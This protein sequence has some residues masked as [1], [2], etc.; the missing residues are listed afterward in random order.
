[1]QAGGPLLS[2]QS[3]KPGEG[4][5]LT[6]PTTTLNLT[7]VLNIWVNALKLKKKFISE[8]FDVVG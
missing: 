5:E 6:V 1:M 3:Y 2:P 4:V 7:N 8:K